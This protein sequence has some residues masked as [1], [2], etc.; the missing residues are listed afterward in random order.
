MDLHTVR[1]ISKKFNISTRML[2]YYE[3][4]GLIKSQRI[5]NYSYRVYDEAE[6]LRLRLI[7]IL[8]KLRISLKQ[9]SDI[10]KNEDIVS[11]L[12]VFKSNINEIDNE[13]DTL[14]TIRTVL[15]QFVDTIKQNTNIQI[16]TDLFNDQSLM[17]VIDSLTSIKAN[18]KTEYITSPAV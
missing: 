17:S 5:E 13:T 4:L 8:R 14:K 16:K 15:C 18:I 11:A 9:I 12:Q 10:L 2:R 3:Q 1:D 6:C 7:I